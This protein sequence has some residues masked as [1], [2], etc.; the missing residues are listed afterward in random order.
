MA[1]TKANSDFFQASQ[2]CDSWANQ[3]KDTTTTKNLAEKNFM[4]SESSLDM[5]LITFK[6]YDFDNIQEIGF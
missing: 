5:I 1:K 3:G 2:N 4:L 6:R